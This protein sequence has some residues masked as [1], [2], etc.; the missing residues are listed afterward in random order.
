MQ[1][2]KFGGKI[3]WEVSALGFGAMRLP[4]LPDGT[5]DEPE[6]I[7]MIRHGIDS[8]INYVDTAYMYHDGISE[9]IVGKA[10]KDGYRSKAKLT[11]KSPV[12]YFKSEDDFDTYLH[13]QLKRLDTDHIDFYLLHSLSLNTWNNV[14]LKF[15]LLDKMDRLKQSGVIDHIGFS[16]HDEN[17]EA[18]KTIVD[19]Y[20]KWEFCQIQ[21]N[22]LD[23]NNQAGVEGLEYAASKGLGVI[24]ME[25]LL[26]GGLANPPEEVKAHFAAHTLSGKEATPVEWALDFLWDRPEVSF[27]LSGMSNMQQLTDNL[28]YADRAHPNMLSTAESKVISGAQQIYAGLI[29]VPCT[30]CQYC[31]PC[32]FGVEIPRIFEAYNTSV[33]SQSLAGWTYSDIQGKAD[34]CTACKKCERICPQKI[35]IS[36]HMH[37][38]VNVFR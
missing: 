6:A 31:M 10:L 12:M 13:T 19:G 25:P 1:Y 17:V 4:C 37:E 2:R 22:Y 27:L 21:L 34:K 9:V 15:N 28:V 14:V 33:R 32:P 3:D 30:K 29:K 24:I 35:K 20:D 26:G 36:E 18:F 16:F 8:G 7:R 23:V 5:V 11:T 38:I